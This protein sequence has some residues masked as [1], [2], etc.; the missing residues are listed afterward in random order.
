[1]GKGQGPYT[2][3]NYSRSIQ[4]CKR[5]NMQ[6]FKVGDCFRSIQGVHKVI[7]VHTGIKLDYIDMEGIDID[8]SRRSGWITTDSAPGIYKLHQW[9]PITL[10][11]YNC[12]KDLWVNSK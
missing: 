2:T 12:I 1:M 8:R 4:L 10:D 7:A 5:S 11:Q 6:K 3:P 9:V